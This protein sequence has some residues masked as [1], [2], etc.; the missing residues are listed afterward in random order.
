MEDLFKPKGFVSLPE[1]SVEPETP[2][3]A[4]TMEEMDNQMEIAKSLESLNSF[5]SNFNWLST[6]VDREPIVPVIQRRQFPVMPAQI[7]ID[8]NPIENVTLG[9]DFVS[10]FVM[11][12][13]GELGVLSWLD[14]SIRE[15]MFKELQSQ[16]H[17]KFKLM[18]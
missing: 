7:V 6:I 9:A 18:P 10:N 8:G 14:E 17:T 16:G 13:P 1:K 11:A 5:Y 2:S 15:S 12:E 4:R 3:V